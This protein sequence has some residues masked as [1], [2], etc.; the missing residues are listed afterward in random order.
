MS[1]SVCVYNPEPDDG[2]DEVRREPTPNGST[3]GSTALNYR[4]LFRT[5]YESRTLREHLRGSPVPA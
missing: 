5:D 3:T 1:C 2:V 4:G